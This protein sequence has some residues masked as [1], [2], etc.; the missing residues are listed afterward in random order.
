MCYQSKSTKNF[1]HFFGDDRS[2]HDQPFRALLKKFVFFLGPENESE[3]PKTSRINIQSDTC[4]TKPQEPLE[5][6][7]R[8]KL[9]SS[10][11][12]QHN[13]LEKIYSKTKDEIPESTPQCGSCIETLLRLKYRFPTVPAFFGDDCGSKRFEEMATFSCQVSAGRAEKLTR[14]IEGNQHKV[15]NRTHFGT[16]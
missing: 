4:I 10:S 3:F 1:S 5:S 13:R 2:S 8:E 12:M 7:S 6:N 14:C 16:S 11:E 15:R 9:F